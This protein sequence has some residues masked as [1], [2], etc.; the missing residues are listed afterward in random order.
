MGIVAVFFVDHYST[1]KL[2]GVFIAIPEN[3]ANF[4]AAE[5]ELL[6]HR[7]LYLRQVLP[8]I[9]HREGK[10]RKEKKWTMDIT[11]VLSHDKNC[12]ILSAKVLKKYH[13]SGF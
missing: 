9:D 1:V 3:N 6:R 7:F 12:G 8:M 2:P 11:T 10:G 13:D 4:S 5:R